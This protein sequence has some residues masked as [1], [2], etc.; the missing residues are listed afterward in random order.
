M[1]HE[2]YN[3]MVHLMRHAKKRRTRIKNAVRFCRW[4][5]KAGVV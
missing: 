5:D 2:K 4:L 1:K 3:R